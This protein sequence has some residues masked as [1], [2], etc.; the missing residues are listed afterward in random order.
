VIPVPGEDAAESPLGAILAVLITVIL[1]LLVLLMALQ[2]PNLWYDP[3]VPD[4]FQITDIKYTL[5]ADGVN[6]IG[7]VDI[8]NSDSKNYRNRYLRINTYVNDN[9]ADCNI[10]TLNNEL[11]ISQAVHTGVSH[12]SGVGTTGGKDSPLSVWPANS[13]IS[14]EYKKGRLH[15]GDNVKLEFVDTTTNH[16]ISRD[17]YPHTN[18]IQ[19]RCMRLYFNHQDT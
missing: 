13:G 9:P 7:L 16:L 15:P 17:T 1:A 2:L 11:F 10:P 12:L 3:T 19:E 18:G 4:I 14:I 8:Y 5:S 6:Y